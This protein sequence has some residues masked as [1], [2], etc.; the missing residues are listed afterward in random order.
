MTT[1][2]IQIDGMTCKCCSSG[3]GKRLTELPGVKKADVDL[4]SGRARVEFDASQTSHEALLAVIR[5]AKFKAR[6]LESTLAA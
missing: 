5:G 3:V 1:T 6:V 2:T 4:A